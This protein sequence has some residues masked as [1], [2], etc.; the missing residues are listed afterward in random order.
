MQ[1][2]GQS[3]VVV[4]RDAGARP[5]AVLEQDRLIGVVAQTEISNLQQDGPQAAGG[6]WS[7][8]TGP[9]QQ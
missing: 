1:Q 9:G 3:E 4:G 6:V 2:L 7:G 8:P 5:A